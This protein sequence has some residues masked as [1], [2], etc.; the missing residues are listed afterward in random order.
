V[1]EKGVRKAPRRE[2]ELAEQG[3]NCGETV[4]IV[5]SAPEK[6]KH[7]SIEN[8]KTQGRTSRKR[9]GKSACHHVKGKSTTPDAGK[10]IPDSKKGALASEKEEN[11]SPDAK[12]E[13]MGRSSLS[14]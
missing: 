10:R 6:K 4:K 13:G 1:K 11:P 3:E 9:K 12:K 14:S 5:A 2:E 8:I 7:H